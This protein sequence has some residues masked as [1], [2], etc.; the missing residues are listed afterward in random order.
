[1]CNY[2]YICLQFELHDFLRSV[3]LLFIKETH[4]KYNDEEN[5]NMIKYKWLTGMNIF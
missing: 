4:P 5:K 1:M 2:V 3:V